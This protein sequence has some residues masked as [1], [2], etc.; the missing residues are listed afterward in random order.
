MATKKYILDRFDDFFVI[1]FEKNNKAN[2]LVILKDKFTIDA[3]IGDLIEVHMNE[4]KS[5]YDFKILKEEANETRQR[6]L[7]LIQGMKKV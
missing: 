7:D 6:L 5:G 3:K 1:L 2:K 4:D